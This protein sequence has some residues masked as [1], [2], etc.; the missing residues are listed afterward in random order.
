MNIVIMRHAEAEPFMG[1]DS[2]RSLT[3][4]GLNQAQ[5][6]GRCMEHL[7][8]AFDE[9][10]VSPYRRTQ[11]TADAVLQSSVLGARKT[12]AVLVPESKPSEV[13]DSIQAAGV[14]RLLLISHQ[15]L[16][17]AL[18]ALLE[19]G[20]AKGGPPMSPASMALLTADMLLPGCCQIQWLRNAP[21]FEAV[22]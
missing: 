21:H 5:S 15:P 2:L 18:V 20:R 22:V 1:Q 8:L 12:K 10:W 19:S 7:S 4:H 16:V 3:A 6:A 11:Q 17:S 14:E 9:I 13:V